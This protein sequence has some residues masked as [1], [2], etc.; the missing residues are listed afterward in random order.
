M[1][2]IFV[3]VKNSHSS[4]PIGK[5][6]ILTGIGEE[7]QLIIRHFHILHGEKNGINL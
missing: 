6:P 2:F 7:K 5:L 3:I 1:W 4:F